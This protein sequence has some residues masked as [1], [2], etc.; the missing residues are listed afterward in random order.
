MADAP[1]QPGSTPEP[2]EARRAAALRRI[3]DRSAEREAQRQQPLPE[4]ASFAVYDPKFCLGCGAELTELEDT[5]QCPHCGRGFNPADDSTY[6]DEPPP[7][8]EVPYWRQPP[9]L[10][11]YVLLPLFLLGRVLIRAVEGQFAGMLDTLGGAMAG[12]LLVVFGLVPWL[13]GCIYLALIAAEDFFSPRLGPALAV[14]LLLGVLLTLGLH[15]ALLV[16]GAILGPFV[17]LIRAWREL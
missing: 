1:D 8:L 13:A 14:G 7:S 12:P 5:T 2:S 3:S 16:I 6:A 4:D 9:R 15:P 11:G 17:G 10:A